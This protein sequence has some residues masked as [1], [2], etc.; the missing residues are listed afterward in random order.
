M[1]PPVSPYVSGGLVRAGLTTLRLAMLTVLLTIG[2]AAAG[3]TS[4]EPNTNRP[5]K[6]YRNFWM[7]SGNVYLCQNACAA[8]RRC[9]A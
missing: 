6:D 9:R 1:I 7:D 8:D 3:A 4:F 5:G 2:A